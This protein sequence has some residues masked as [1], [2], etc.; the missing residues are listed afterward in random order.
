MEHYKLPEQYVYYVE[1][2]RRGYGIDTASCL[3]CKHCTDV[4]YDYSNGP[5]M[6]MCDLD[7][8]FEDC[9]DKFELDESIPTV[10]EFLREHPSF[11]CSEE[12]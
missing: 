5:Y 11:K 6:T 4:F 10:K 9:P 3:L 7:F 1:E 2:F 8:S 12:A